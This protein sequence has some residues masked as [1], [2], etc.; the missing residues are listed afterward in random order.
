MTFPTSDSPV[1]I[2]DVPFL[3]STLELPLLSFHSRVP[4]LGFRFLEFPPQDPYWQTNTSSVLVLGVAGQG[5]MPEFSA[6]EWGAS[7]CGCPSVAWPSLRCPDLGSER[8]ASGPR[9][10]SVINAVPGIP[11]GELNPGIRTLVRRVE[12]DHSLFPILPGRM[13]RHEPNRRN[14]N[15][16]TPKLENTKPEET[17]PDNQNPRKPNLSNP[18][19][20]KQNRRNT[21]HL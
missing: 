6:A 14:P 11:H 13:K 16:R 8:G 2:M 15:P 3:S 17:K 7:V 4:T 9:C 20:G 19:P 21:K 5:C 1:R 10:P 12:M 18:D